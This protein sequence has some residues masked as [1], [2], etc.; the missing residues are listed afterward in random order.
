MQIA[1]LIQNRLVSKRIT[2]PIVG[3]W[4]VEML[5]EFV[6][7]AEQEHGERINRRSEWQE[8]RLADADG[9]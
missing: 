2:T 5:A 3:V 8:H 6:A 1:E 4:S 7:V 9:Q